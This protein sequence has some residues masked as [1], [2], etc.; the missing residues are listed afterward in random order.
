MAEEYRATH[1]ERTELL[2]QWESILEQMKRR[3]EAIQRTAEELEAVKKEISLQENALEEKKGFLDNEEGEVPVG[4]LSCIPKP[5][6]H[7][8]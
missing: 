6:L 7:R 5:H 4:D 3:D 2:S 1:K 8:L